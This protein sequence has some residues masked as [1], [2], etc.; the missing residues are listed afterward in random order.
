MRPRE[1]AMRF[2]SRASRVTRRASSKGPVSRSAFAKLE[3][4]PRVWGSVLSIRWVQMKCWERTS[5]MSSSRSMD[6]CFRSTTYDAALAC[7]RYSSSMRWAMRA[8]DGRDEGWIRRQSASSLPRPSGSRSWDSSLRSHSQ[9]A[10]KPTS[11]SSRVMLSSRT[12]VMAQP[13]ESTASVTGASIRMG[14]SRG[15]FFS[16]QNSL[17]SSICSGA[18]NWGQPPSSEGWRLTSL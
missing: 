1:M 13:H 5:R 18:Q 10:A 6:G 15:H 17:S 2:I 3:A 9:K 8:H 4:A 16:P 12:I 11:H 7:T 14:A